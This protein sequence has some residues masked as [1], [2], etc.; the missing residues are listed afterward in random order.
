[1]KVLIRLFG[2][3]AEEG[4]LLTL[5]MP[6][7]PTPGDV[8]DTYGEGGVGGV[9]VVRRRHWFMSAEAPKAP[10]LSREAEAN[11]IIECDHLAASLAPSPLPSNVIPLVPRLDSRLTGPVDR[12]DAL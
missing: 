12:S 8:V 1:M 11:V 7:I 6:S 5:D 4:V 10:G 9:Y 2:G 3:L